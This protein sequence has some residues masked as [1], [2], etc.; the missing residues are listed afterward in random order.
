LR[1]TY[2]HGLFFDAG[3]AARK[4]GV[5]LH[6][7]ADLAGD[8]QKRKSTT[9]MV[10]MMYGTPVMWMSKLQ[11]VTAMSTAEAEFIASAMAARKDYG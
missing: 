11:S 1:G 10:L 4:Q 7:D 2:D 3:E 9:G 6:A 8:N 5:L